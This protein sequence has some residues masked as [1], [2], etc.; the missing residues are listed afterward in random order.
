MGSVDG[1][2]MDVLDRLWLRCSAEGRTVKFSNWSE[3]ASEL[4]VDLT[5]TRLRE[6]V[7]KS[8]V[9][10]GLVRYISPTRQQRSDG[11]WPEG[12]KLVVL[13]PAKSKIVRRLQVGSISILV[14]DTRLAHLATLFGMPQRYVEEALA[15]LV[16]ESKVT[17][18]TMA[19][20][21]S[22]EKYELSPDE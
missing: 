18:T 13:E 16:V 9:K 1:I 21:K 19:G 15:E 6:V 17:L 3:L 10:Q 4:R 7:T 8:L 14:D 11:G 2:A 22:Y 12:H 5:A 20:R